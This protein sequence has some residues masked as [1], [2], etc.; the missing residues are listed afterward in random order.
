MMH[1]SYIYIFLLLDAEF[2][3]IVVLETKMLLLLIYV[4]SSSF[5]CGFLI[6]IVAEI[7]QQ[8]FN[9]AKVR[10]VV[11]LLSRD[12]RHG[13]LALLLLHPGRRSRAVG[14]RRRRRVA[15]VG[16]L[17]ERARRGRRWSG[18]VLRDGHLRDALDEGSW[19]RGASWRRRRSR[20]WHRDA[21][22]ALRSCS[23]SCDGDN[24]R[25]GR[26]RRSWR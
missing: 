6:E 23:A 13:R 26:W 20:R 14:T 17:R 25:A 15:C 8:V 11:L 16:S 10:E 2:N 21:S 3:I 4:Y 9:H 19:R 1:I 22:V 24:R 7:A 12:R 18:A 5:A